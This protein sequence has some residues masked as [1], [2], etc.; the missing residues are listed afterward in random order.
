VSRIGPDAEAGGHLP[1]LDGLVPA[2]GEDVV[3]AGQ[4]GHAAHIVVMPVH[5]LWGR[6]SAILF[7]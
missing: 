4:E 5:R 3:A 7:Y 1:H 6:S 2:R